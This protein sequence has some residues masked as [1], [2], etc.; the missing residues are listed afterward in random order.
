VSD[1][2]DIADKAVRQQIAKSV[3]ESI[4]AGHRDVIFASAI[5]G[6]L[7]S[8]SY[9]DSVEKAVAKAAAHQAEQLI[10]TQ[11]WQ[12]RIKFVVTDSMNEFLQSLRPAMLDSLQELFGGKTGDRTYEQGPGLILKHLHKRLQK[13][14]P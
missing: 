6:A 3:L 2:K 4:D 12:D 13:E 11:E 14:Q 8:Y 7:A 9:K 10:Q 1:L 5:E